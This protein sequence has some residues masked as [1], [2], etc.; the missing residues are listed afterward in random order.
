MVN[1]GNTLKP[2]LA[3]LS[4]L[5]LCLMASPV[6][7]DETDIVTANKVAALN[8]QVSLKAEKSKSESHRSD[9][10]SVNSLSDEFVF[11][12]EG[13]KLLLAKNRIFSYALK[14]KIERTSLRGK[15]KLDSQYFKGFLTDTVYC[16]DIPFTLG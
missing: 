7:A 9:Y 1:P 8:S 16:C 10:F 5:G 4:T 2:W 13:D 15:I 14:D 11:E 12:S 6:L 3:I